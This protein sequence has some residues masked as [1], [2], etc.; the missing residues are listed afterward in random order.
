MR[1][2]IFT[3]TIIITITVSAQ[4]NCNFY[5]MEGDSCRYKACSYLESAPKYFQL[6]GEYHSIYNKVL[7][8]CPE[9]GDAYRAK[10]TAYLKTG[11][12]ITWKALM[13][14]AVSI[15]PKDNLS[16][17]GWCRFQFLRDY[18]GAI[19]DIEKLDS[20]VSH[21]IGYSQNGTYHLNIAKGLCYKM[22]G[23]TEKSISIIEQQI[24]SD[25][26]SIGLY[27]YLHLGV[28]YQELGQHEKS[29]TY[30]EKQQEEYN[31][32][33]N[34]YYTAISHKK[35]GNK[36]QYQLYIKKADSLYNNNTIMLD[37]YTHQVDKVYHTTIQKELNTEETK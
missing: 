31:C 15:N 6:R 19:R 10:S 25:A 22:I 36:T 8:I 30:F 20:L 34:A 17:R 7:E 37:P 16:Y 33:E 11:D 27:D 14:K 13:D 21:D 12:F 18:K 26:F 9:Y 29:L 5:K 24:E 28:L 1:K 32:A 35:L 3:F 4:R 23:E 2:Y